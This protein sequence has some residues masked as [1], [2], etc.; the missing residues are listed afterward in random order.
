MSDS[1]A[2]QF[3]YLDA[4]AALAHRD[5]RAEYAQLAAERDRVAA[6]LRASELELAFHLWSDD[7]SRAHI[8]LYTPGVDGMDAELDVRVLVPGPCGEDAAVQ[9]LDVCGDPD[10]AEWLAL[11]ERGVLEL[12]DAHQADTCTAR[13]V[14]A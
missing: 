6:R 13:A 11:N 2:L 14:E 12:Y 5:G 1:L 4:R 9:L 3:A 8:W 10:A 7:G